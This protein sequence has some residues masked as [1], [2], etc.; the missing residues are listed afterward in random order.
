MK[1]F[2]INFDTKKLEQDIKNKWRLE[3]LNERDSLGQN[4]S[5][6]LQK[7]DIAEV[8][9]CEACKTIRY[10]SDGKKALRLHAKDTNHRNN[11]KTVK[12]NQVQ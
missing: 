10:K 3:W 9:V 12:S 8:G 7:P 6:W 1:F 4:W 2:D 5:E 11:L